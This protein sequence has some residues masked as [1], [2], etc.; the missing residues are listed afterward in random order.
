M[1]HAVDVI[2]Q[3]PDTLIGILTL[4]LG[5][6]HR[7]QAGTA[8]QDLQVVDG[9]EQSGISAQMDH[10]RQRT[11]HVSCVIFCNAAGIKVQCPKLGK[12]DRPVALQPCQKEIPVLLLQDRIAQDAS[13]KH[14]ACKGKIIIEHG[15]FQK[16]ML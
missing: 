3:L 9:N 15:I 12:L 13:R 11:E 14:A 7:F 5:I 4:H 2:D 10:F 6:M 1:L 16:N 8:D